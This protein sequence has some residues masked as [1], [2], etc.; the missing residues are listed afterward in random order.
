MKVIRT[1]SDDRARQRLAISIV[2]GRRNT[3]PPPQEARRDDTSAG[4]TNSGA[5]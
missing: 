3:V 4:A 1:G 5:A 2:L